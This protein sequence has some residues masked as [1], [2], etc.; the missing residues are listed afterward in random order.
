MKRDLLTG[1]VTALVVT[2]G[3]ATGY[4]QTAGETPPLS[5]AASAR[6]A[7][8][9]LDDKAVYVIT[10]YDHLQVHGAS[11]RHTSLLLTENDTARLA[12]FNDTLHG[13]SSFDWRGVHRVQYR[14]PES[15]VIEGNLARLANSVVD[16]NPRTLS[17]SREYVASHTA[18]SPT[19]E[20]VA[21]SDGHGGDLGAILINGGYVFS[22]TNDA[23]TS[24]TTTNRW[25]KLDT[26]DMENY[27]DYAGYPEGKCPALLTALWWTSDDMMEF[28]YGVKDSADCSMDR[29][30]PA[31]TFQQYR[32]QVKVAPAGADTLKVATTVKP[33][34]PPQS[35][36]ALYGMITTKKQ[37]LPVK[38][39]AFETIRETYDASELVEVTGETDPATTA[40]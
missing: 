21:M 29:A 5:A 19:G 9:T 17:V 20:Y 10:R 18:V 28:V 1:W 30:D 35:A 23:I 7:Y 27:S 40:P 33:I 12:H 32:V 26:A 34:D 11:A 3:C 6:I 2:A 22:L 39:V 13:T 8:D 25:S 4:C 14:S 31:E 37:R 38:A 15:I 36:E 16:F 24:A